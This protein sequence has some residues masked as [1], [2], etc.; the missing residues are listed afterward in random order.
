MLSQA[1]TTSKNFG[2]L[3]AWHCDNGAQKAPTSPLHGMVL[4]QKVQMATR[5]GKSLTRKFP[6][7]G[8]VIEALVLIELLLQLRLQ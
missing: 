8:L 7:I 2:W 3:E 4:D 5:I 6:K 1:E